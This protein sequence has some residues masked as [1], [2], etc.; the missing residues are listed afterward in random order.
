MK[1]DGSAIS[2]FTNVRTIEPGDV[3]IVP[4]KEEEKI[5]ALS[6]I[7]DIAD[8]RRR[9]APWASRPWWRSS[10]CRERRGQSAQG[11]APNAARPLEKDPKSD[12]MVRVV[13]IVAL[14]LAV[15][16]RAESQP[17]LPAA[18]DQ[19]VIRVQS[20]GNEM[21]VMRQAP[22]A[23]STIEQ[24]YAGIG[25]PRNVGPV[26]SAVRA[27][28]PEE[29]DYLF[30]RHQRRH[31]RSGRARPHGGGRRAR[32]CS[33]GARSSAAIRRCRFPRGGSGSSRCR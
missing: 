14:A 17:R 24:I 27:S 1:A 10:S 21:I 22:V 28:P 13:S 31:P 32:P 18:L 5:R 4:P 30:L 20:Q 2:S 9:G 33:R 11:L 3:V 6:T 19:A 29:I 7:R 12:E 25:S 8:D 16:A 26:P 23:Y 15:V